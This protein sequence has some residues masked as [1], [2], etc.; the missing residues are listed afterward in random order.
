MGISI[1]N[2]GVHARQG[3]TTHCCSL[4]RCD[5]IDDVVWIVE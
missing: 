4:L 1:S 3:A 2:T 5:R